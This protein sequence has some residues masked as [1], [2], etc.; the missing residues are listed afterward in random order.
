MKY[1]T[2][3]LYQSSSRLTRW[4]HKTVQTRIKKD[5]N[6]ISMAGV[7]IRCAC[8]RIAGMAMLP[9]ADAPVK[10]FAASIQLKWGDKLLV[11]ENSDSL[12]K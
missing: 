12:H 11:N 6:S 7:S 10:N 4:K 5:V 1:D 8:L 9:T 3:W 2:P